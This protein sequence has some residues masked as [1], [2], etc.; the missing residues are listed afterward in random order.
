M[1]KTVKTILYR[2]KI[3]WYIYKKERKEIKD[4]I[5]VEKGED[6]LSVICHI[7]IKLGWR[8]IYPNYSIYESA[9]KAL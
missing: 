6:A 1:E 7:T 9:V 2:N 8:K 5:I 4:G 3:N